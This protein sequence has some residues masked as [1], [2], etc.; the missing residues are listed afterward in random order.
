MRK[1][2]R[3]FTVTSTEG[4]KAWR[5]ANPERWRAHQLR[6]RQKNRRPCRICRGKMPFPSMG[7]KYCDLC[8]PTARQRSQRRHGRKRLQL[9]AEYKISRG[10][11]RCN[12]RGCAAALDFHH[13]EPQTRHHRVWVPRGTEYEK[14]I[15]LCSNC[16]HELHEEKRGGH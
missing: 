16:H 15:L 10:C 7:R 2:R 1:V 3:S 9:L 5:I 8:Q 12:Y 11:D 13:T 6:Y 4:N 14:C